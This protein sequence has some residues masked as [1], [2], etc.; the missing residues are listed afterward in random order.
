[1]IISAL[2]VYKFL[3]TQHPYYGK[4]RV[5]LLK[6]FTSTAYFNP[7]GRGLLNQ[8]LGRVLHELWNHVPEPLVQNSEAPF[9][10]PQDFGAAIFCYITTEL[11][12]TA[13]EQT[14]S[15][16]NGNLSGQKFHSPVMLTSNA[17]SHSWT[18]RIKPESSP[19]NL[20]FC[21]FVKI[22]IENFTR[23]S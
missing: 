9:S 2:T 12:I 22:Q 15:S 23:I 6:L 4:L 3:K 1:M 16:Q 13:Y 7:R 21:P 10:P 19:V 14:M 18:N 20:R 8:Y 17:H 11:K 5:Q